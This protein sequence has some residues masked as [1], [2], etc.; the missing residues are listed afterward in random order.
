MGVIF[1]VLGSI[2]IGG[3]LILM[4]M[5][6]Q[7]QLQ[8]SAERLMYV[9]SMIEHMDTACTRVNKLFALAGVGI[10]VDSVVVVAATNRVVFRTYWN[11]DSDTLSNVRHL[12]EFNIAN[13]ANPYGKALR[14][15]QN[16][17]TLEDIGYIMYVE[18]MTLRYYDKN[19]A[20]TTSPGAVRSAE[21]LLTFRRD[22]TWRPN[23]P[24]RSNIQMRCYFMNSYLQ[25]G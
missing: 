6:F 9:G 14:I 24:L 5:T 19:D 23:R 21:V 18:G 22:S 10:P 11:C 3:M 25:G 8:E 17:S 4:V 15:T 7:M 2:V 1:D 20:I 16:G 13:V 12:I